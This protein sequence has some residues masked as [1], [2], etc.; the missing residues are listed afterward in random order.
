M[1]FTYSL[2]IT[3]NCLNDNPTGEVLATWDIYDRNVYFPELKLFA[4]TRAW[5]AGGLDAMH[6]LKWRWR[7][8][9]NFEA[10]RDAQRTGEALRL[11]AACNERAFEYVR[12]I[13]QSL[14]VEDEYETTDMNL[15]AAL[16]V[17][18]VPVIKIEGAPGGRVYTLPRYGVPRMIEGGYRTEDVYVLTQ[19]EVPGQLDLVI[20]KTAPDHPVVHAYNALHVWSQLRTEFKKQRQHMLLQFP[21]WTQRRAVISECAGSRV[22]DRLRR[23]LKLPSKP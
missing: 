20:E 15:A 3:E 11:Q 16:S 23:H 4:L 22:L 14:T 21:R 10:L 1:G 7:A 12:G 17:I 9:N 6:P 5:Q 18:G 19:R 13:P 8:C 2:S